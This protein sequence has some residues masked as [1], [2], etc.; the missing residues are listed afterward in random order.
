MAYRV[1]LDDAKGRLLELIE[2]AI[3]GEEV[4]ILKDQNPV[5]KLEPV[6]SSKRRPKFGSA[7]GLVAMAEDFDAPLEAFS[8]YMP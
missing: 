5:V 7:R 4:F 1:T 3:H 6:V 2:L 8:E